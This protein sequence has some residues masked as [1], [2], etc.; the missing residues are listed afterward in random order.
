[1]ANLRATVEKHL[2]AQIGYLEKVMMYENQSVEFKGQLENIN[3]MVET[4][5]DGAVTFKEI[6]LLVTFEHSVKTI[7]IMKSYSRGWLVLTLIRTDLSCFF[8]KE[9][10]Q[11]RPTVL[12]FWLLS[13]HRGMQF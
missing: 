8:W 9:N 6:Q 10:F 5:Y 12:S 11:P 3:T 1:M 2:S 7:F 4:D 13:F